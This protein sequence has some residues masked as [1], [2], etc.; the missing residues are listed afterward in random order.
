MKSFAMVA[1]LAAATLCTVRAQ[2]PAPGWV[3]SGGRT[4]GAFSWR[5][6]L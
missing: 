4:G 1:A 2:D 6:A 5:A 3:V